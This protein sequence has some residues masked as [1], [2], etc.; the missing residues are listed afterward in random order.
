MSYVL[1]VKL[2]CFPV[3]GSLLFIIRDGSML[4]FID[5]FKLNHLK[6]QFFL[7]I[8]YVGFHQLNASLFPICVC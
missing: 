3:C 4:R 5:F 2:A 1:L 8:H 6:K 7:S